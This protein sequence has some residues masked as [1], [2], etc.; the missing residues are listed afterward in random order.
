VFP[1]LHKI[2]FVH[3]CYWHRHPDCRYTYAP[4][5]NV[6]FWQAK[7]DANVARD[8]RSV[9]ELEKLGWQV[10][11]I[12]ECETKNEGK[13]IRRLATYLKNQTNPGTI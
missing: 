12:W 10:H 2:I 1:R 9:A 3:G 8:R 4:K 5:S 7:F 11:V 13:L 6:A